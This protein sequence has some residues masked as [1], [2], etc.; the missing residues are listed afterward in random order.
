M[1]VTRSRKAYERIPVYL[2]VWVR[3]GKHYGSL[4]SFSSTGS[5]RNM[6][7]NIAYGCVWI[8]YMLGVVRYDRNNRFAIVISAIYSRFT[9]YS[10]PPFFK[11]TDASCFGEA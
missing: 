6:D 8:H 3:D 9:L 11:V 2:F 4:V 7:I 5:T 1:N 10:F